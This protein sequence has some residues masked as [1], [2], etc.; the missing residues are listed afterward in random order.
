MNKIPVGYTVLEYQ[1]K[2]DKVIVGVYELPRMTEKVP[3]S[4]IYNDKRYYRG[5]LVPVPDNMIGKVCS[6]REYGNKKTEL[7]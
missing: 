6:T 7:Y 5:L 2:R 4:I 1:E 3:E